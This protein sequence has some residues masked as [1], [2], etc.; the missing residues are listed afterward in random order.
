MQFYEAKQKSRGLQYFPV[1]VAPEKTTVA[2]LY[3]YQRLS[4]KK[5]ALSLWLAC[6]IIFYKLC[7]F[8]NE[9]SF[10]VLVDNQFSDVLS[11]TSHN[12]ILSQISFLWHII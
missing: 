7:L 11:A 4:D 5:D 1:S 3:E 2:T 12:T 9:P 6:I 8:R 10:K